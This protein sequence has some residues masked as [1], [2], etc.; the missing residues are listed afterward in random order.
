MSKIDD[1]EQENQSA[2]TRQEVNRVLEVGKLLLSVLEPS[3]LEELAEF[4][5][6]EADITDRFT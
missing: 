1:A 2:A 6:E 5:K 3:E 4:V